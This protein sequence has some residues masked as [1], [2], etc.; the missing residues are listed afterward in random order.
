MQE[1]LVKLFNT[2]DPSQT[3]VLII[4]LGLSFLVGALVWALLAHFP[5]IRKLRKEKGLLE[6]KATFLEKENK[7]YK[8]RNT[9][10][11][12]NLKR[13]KESLATSETNLKE[14]SEKLADQSKKLQK[15][16]E[17]LS[18]YKDNARS[19]KENYEELMGNFR[20]LNFEHK[21][22]H[23]QLKEFKLIIEEEEQEKS[24]LEAETKTA[25][26][27]AKQADIEKQKIQKHLDKAQETI[28]LLKSDLD[29][30]LAQKAE[31]KRIAFELEASK[32][33]KGTNDEELKD[34]VVRLQAH[35]YDLEAENNDLLQQLMPY[36]RA[37]ENKRKEEKE[38]ENSMIEALADAEINM[39]NDGFYVGYEN[40]KLIE[41]TDY[42]DQTLANE[43]EEE[44]KNP[45]PEATEENILIESYEEE[46]MEKQLKEAKVAM[47][48]QGFYEDI[49]EPVLVQAVSA[50]DHLNDEELME[51]VLEET[52]AIFEE[53]PLFVDEIQQDELIENVDL[54]DEKLQSDKEATLE[55]TTDETEI[56]VNDIIA[57]EHQEMEDALEQALQAMSKEG[58]YAPIDSDKLVGEDS[59]EDEI[60]TKKLYGSELERLVVQ[61]VGDTIPTAEENRKD[62]LKKIDGIGMFLEE[63]L[64]YFGI[65]T[66]EQISGFDDSFIQKLTAAIGF[67]EDTIYRDKWV[68]QARELL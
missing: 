27:T 13:T 17:Q 19:Y 34:K 2:G 16:A 33:L 21:K 46:E 40:N 53:N 56:A 57:E 6:D 7:D 65:Y 14:K 35:V 32:N 61:E 44:E 10:L 51:K 1:A 62:D 66:Y 50:D 41:D 12:A 29:E 15:T 64:N 9:V 58:L 47:S 4:L 31:L 54:L 39:N 60:S 52:H 20:D 8:E 42:L 24:K 11:S 38:I 3:W 30:A 22:A 25:Q 48:L 67:S 37:E 55:E 18:L 26:K 59:V 23:I 36:V 43:A 45:L 49:E 28:E 63:Q 68:E 5:A